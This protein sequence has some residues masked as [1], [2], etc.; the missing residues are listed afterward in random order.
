M[1][2][3]QTTLNTWASWESFPLLNG[4]GGAGAVGGKGE[5]MEGGREGKPIGII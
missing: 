1:G 5:G 3:G 2:Q 4:D